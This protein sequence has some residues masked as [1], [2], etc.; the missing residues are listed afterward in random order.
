[1]KDE[2]SKSI[3]ACITLLGDIKEEQV[4]TQKSISELDKTVALFTQ[5]TEMELKK[6]HEL[7]AQQNILL[8]EH[9]Q[10]SA[11]LERQNDL[12]EQ[13]LRKDILGEGHPNP[14]ITL[15]GRVEIL[16]KPQKWL[17]MTKSLVI[18]VGT[19]SAA[20]YAIWKMYTTWM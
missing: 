19:I 4:N 11:Q 6:I 9:S 3:D 16:E 2:H 18:G 10:R 15:A 12:I 20:L 8:E 17:S 5:K 13:G 7:D 14:K 1:M